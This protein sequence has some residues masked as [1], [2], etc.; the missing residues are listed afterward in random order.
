MIKA[1]LF[2]LDD[3]LIRTKES[4]SQAIIQTA[5]QFY[6]LDIKTDQI[7]QHWGKPFRQ[8]MEILFAGVDQPDTVLKNYASIRDRYP[9]KAYPDAI[10]VLNKLASDY[11]IGIIS[12]ATR[13]QVISDLTELSFPIDSFFRIQTMEDTLIHKPDPA[14]FKPTLTA[15][16]AV[17]IE[18]SETVYVGD[19]LFDYYAARDAMINFIGIADRTTP[20]HKFLE[21]GARIITNLN[22]LLS[23]L[24]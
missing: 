9:A 17:N 6:N 12:S 18:K 7:N 8:F 10:S 2:D 20:K 14:V 16:Q 1:I 21:A 13:T 24:N 19:T 4:K 23:I 3:T 15:L 5:K 22:E 11:R